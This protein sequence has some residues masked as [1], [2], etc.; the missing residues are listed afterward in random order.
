MLLWESADGTR[1][2]G[3]DDPIMFG[4]RHGVAPDQHPTLQRM[5]KMLEQ[6]SERAVG[7]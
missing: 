1:Y 7:D 2:I 4:D 5:R 3:Y 6:L